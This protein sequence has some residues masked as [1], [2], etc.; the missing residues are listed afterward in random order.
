MKPLSVI[1]LSLTISVMLMLANPSFGEVTVDPCGFSLAMEENAEAVIELVLSN[2]GETEVAFSVEYELMEDEEDRRGGPRRDDLGDLIH[3]FEPPQAG[4]GNQYVTGMAW[5]WDNSWMWL[6]ESDNLR[7]VA[8][9]PADDYNEAARFNGPGTDRD[10]TSG[11]AW[12]DGV[13][14]MVGWVN[15]DY[16]YRYDTEGNNIGNLNMP[17]SAGACTASNENGWLF[18][19]CANVIYVYDIEND[20]EEIGRFNDYA[21]FLENQLTQSMCWIDLHP[22]GQL[23]LNTRDGNGD[24][25]AWEVLVD[26]D[27]WESV[28]LVQSYVSEDLQIGHPRDGIGHDGVNLWLANWTERDLRIVDDGIREF[29]MI[30]PE[31]ESG[32]IPAEDSET[33]ALHISSEDCEA[34]EY[35]MLITFELSEVEGRRDDLE[36]T[37]IWISAVVMVGDP[38]YDIA[39]AVTDAADNRSVEGAAVRLDRYIITRFSDEDG[40]YSFTDM[41]PGSYNI[42]FSATDYLPTNEEVT[43]VDGDIDLNVAL[44]HSEFT[45]S[46]YRFGA[47]LEPDMSEAFDFVAENGGNGTLTY[48]ASRRLVGEANADPWAVRYEVNAEEASGDNQ[49]NGVVVVDGLMYV[50]GGDGGANTNLI[51]VFDQEGNLVDQFEQFFESRYGM[52]DLTYDGTLIWGADGTTLYGFTT[53]GELE[54]TIDGGA[55]SYRALAWDVDRQV[56]WSADVTSDIFATNLEGNQVGMIDVPVETRLYGLSYWADD[57]D[58]YCLYIFT[59]GDVEGIECQVNKLN[60]ATGEQMVVMALADVAG[61][62]GGFDVTNQYDVYSWVVAGMVQGPPDRVIVWQLE[63]RR[64]WFQVEPEAGQI[65]DGQSDDFHLTLDATGLPSGNT[66]NGEVVFSHDGVG[67]E[68][69]LSVSLEVAEGEFPSSRNL[70]LSIG[71]N[72]ISVNLVPDNEDVEVIMADLVEA[73][74]LIIM[75]DGEGHF[76]IPE[77]GHNSIPGW[78]VDQGYQV[79]MSEAATLEILGV[80]VLRDRPI[81]LHE[82]WQIVSYYPRSPVD[83]QVAL[84][85]IV[86]HLLIAKDGLGNFYVPAWD[87]SNMG[88]MRE[89]QGYYLKMDADDELIYQINGDNEGAAALGS[90]AQASRPSSPRMRGSIYN[91]PG[92]LPVHP[93]TGENMSLLVRIPPLSPP[94]LRRGGEVAVYACGAMVGTGVLRDGVCGI[95]VWGDDQTTKEVDGALDGQ[96]LMLMLSDADA[97]A[98]MVEV[99]CQ[100][101][102]GEMVYRKDALTVVELEAASIVPTEFAI[103]SV[104]PN[105]FNNTIQIQYSLPE[106]SEIKLSVYDLTGREVEVLFSGGQDA[107]THQTLWNSQGAANGTYVLRLESSGKIRTQKMV[108][109]K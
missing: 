44:L 67:G 3:A 75:K 66:F 55:R 47:V 74:Q 57:P 72:L 23:W 89:G 103:T 43:I 105:P 95:A 107:G 61:R 59:R 45:P 22:R 48:S 29:S 97:D 41:P 76:Y 6:T 19:M 58:G 87:Y 90:V 7:V 71:W 21:Q 16:L 40:N 37:F 86:H 13:L 15:H 17:A 70:N 109:I 50:S 80:T 85:G 18:A 102:A 42:T 24:D 100:V 91:L 52:R 60:V 30:T 31:P 77:F 46:Q 49:L 73:G 51:H 92:S 20:F 10:G 9:D 84:S 11:A 12:Y 78:F 35:N 32:I 94:L 108:L 88:D 53:E 69:V 98:K 25:V 93:V 63:G 28:E 64:D 62:P 99:G 2:D 101:L 33:V 65:A 26:I 54:Q 34:G 38:A 8:V 39:G 5:D 106:A 81:D 56:F 82:G 14:Y 83:A 1:S 68:T 4:L 36:Q 96:P 27:N 79:K 104:Y